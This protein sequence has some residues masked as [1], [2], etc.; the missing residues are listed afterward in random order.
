MCA[1]WYQ[2]TFQVVLMHKTG[3]HLTNHQK[4]GVNKALQHSYC[5]V[6]QSIGNKTQERQ[7]DGFPIHCQVDD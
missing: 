2:F 4:R 7:Y 3:K 6:G 5:A 1:D